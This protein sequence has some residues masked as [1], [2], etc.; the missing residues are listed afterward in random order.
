MTAFDSKPISARAPDRGVTSR[1]GQPT[2]PAAILMAPRPEPGVR[3][4]RRRSDTAQQI[5]ALGELAGGIAHDFRNVLAVISSALHLAERHGNDPGKTREYLSAAQD[6]VERGLRLTSRLLALSKP[7]AP[8]LRLE[9]PGKLIRELLPFLRSGAGPRVSL[10]LELQETA[11]SFLVDPPQ[12]NQALLN[13]VV[14]ARDAMPGGGEIVIESG[15]AP[16]PDGSQD[17]FLRIRVSDSG[18]GMS[19]ETAARIFEPWFTT[20]G[21]TGTGLGLPQVHRFM[22]LVGGSISVSST[23][24]SGTSFD[25]LFPIRDAAPCGNRRAAERA[26]PIARKRSSDPPRPSA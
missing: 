13:L 17:R 10:R 2:S 20:K 6:S 26:G 7:H 25:L 5:D 19:K 23:P 21:E 15:V 24:G 11:V 4:L 1:I 12:F 8:D 16:P 9:D 3:G 18:Q 22:I 14:N